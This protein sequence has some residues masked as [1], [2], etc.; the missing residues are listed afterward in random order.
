MTPEILSIFF[1][2][3]SWNNRTILHTQQ[4][5][6]R[7]EWLQQPE[8]KCGIIDRFKTISHVHPI[9]KNPGSAAGGRLV[10]Y[11][12]KTIFDIS[13]DHPPSFTARKR[14]VILEENIVA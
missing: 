6:D 9:I 2:H 14:I 8:L 1:H 12:L 7:C 13:S 10:H 5:Q 11:S 3:F 4:T